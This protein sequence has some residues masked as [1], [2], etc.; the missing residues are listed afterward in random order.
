[1]VSGL[2][3]L[4]GAFT[5]AADSMVN[6]TA[7]VDFGTRRGA[8]TSA[9]VINGVGS[10]GQVLGGLLPGLVG[11]RVADWNPLFAG[12]AAGSVFAALLMAPRWN[13]VPPSKMVAAT[14]VTDATHADVTA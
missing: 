11:D 8:S 12:L 3:A 10:L 9:G 7:A 5:Y 1:M 13:A 6:G 4:T 2:L 14:D